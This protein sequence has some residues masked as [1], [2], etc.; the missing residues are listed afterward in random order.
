MHEN[1]PF[2]K[3]IISEKHYCILYFSD[4]AGDTL[5]VSTVVNMTDSLMTVNRTYCFS[6]AQFKDKKES[7]LYEISL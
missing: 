1:E 3:I 5:S 2:I 6:L 7:F 4:K